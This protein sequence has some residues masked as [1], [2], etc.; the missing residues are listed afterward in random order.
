MQRLLGS[1]SS[2]LCL[3]VDSACMSPL[4][5]GNK[6]HLGSG[7]PAQTATY[8]SQSQPLEAGSESPPTPPGHIPP[9]GADCSIPQQGMGPSFWPQNDWGKGWDQRSPAHWILNAQKMGR[10][11]RGEL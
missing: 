11:W 7:R 2:D 3:A 5:K 9:W 10:G 1:A 4:T 8:G 6:Q